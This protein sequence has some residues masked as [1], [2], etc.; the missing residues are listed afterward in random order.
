MTTTTLPRGLRPM[1]PAVPGLH[2]FRRIDWYW[3]LMR[4]PMALLAVPA[5]YG[6]GAFM[7]EFLPFVVAV[8]A[9]AG[10]ETAYIGAIAMADQQ[11]DEN[12]QASLYLW[13]AVNVGAVLAS[14]VCNLLFVSGFRFAHVTPESF[15]HAVPMPVVNFLYGLMLHRQ[16][17]K[18]AA[19][20]AME[21]AAQKQREDEE[22][23][24]CP[25]CNT[26]RASIAA[27]RGHQRHCT[28]RPK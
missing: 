7:H 15:V 5:A 23:Y 14:V 17:A 16:A 12:D 20:A 24:R 3:W 26:G 2:W 25:W 8:I 6:V 22:R 19:R 4:L 10:F 11:H 9:G 27:V 21:A 1:L 18:A 13:W 28:A